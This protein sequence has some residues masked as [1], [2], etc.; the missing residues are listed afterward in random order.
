MP[1]ID[2]IGSHHVPIADS[3]V[4]ELA[5]QT[6]GNKTDTA[7]AT[8]DNTSSLMRYVKRLMGVGAAS[9][10][11]TTGP[12]SYLDAGGEQ[13]VYED[14]ATA[15]RKVTIFLSNRNMTQTGTFRFYVEVDGSNYDLYSTDPV[16]IAAGQNRAVSYDLIVVNQAFKITYEEDADEGAARAIPYEV[17]EE[18]LE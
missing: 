11:E 15:R 16:G 17:I 14:T 6:I 3:A 5:T 4:N 7:Q 12:F 9:A 8:I 1:G 10:G 13:D 2:D 18:A